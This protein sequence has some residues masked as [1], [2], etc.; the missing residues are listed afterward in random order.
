[1]KFALLPV[2]LF[3]SSFALLAQ[4]ITL[5][6]NP[7][8]VVFCGQPGQVVSSIPVSVS[9][10]SGSV[11]Y[12]VAGI[13]SDGNWLT[14]N[15]S[16]ATATT[17][18]YPELLVGIQGSV[19]PFPAGTYTGQITLTDVNGA[20]LGVIPVSLQVSVDGC[21]A[22]QTGLLFPN[23]GPLTFALPQ[24]VKSGTLLN[25]FNTF[26]T[27]VTVVPETST[28]NGQNWL[29]TIG[30]NLTVVT[31]LPY[32]TPLGVGVDTTSLTA[33]QSYAG[34]VVVN[35]SVS[36]SLDIPVTVLV[37][38]ADS[39]GIVA[40]PSPLSLTI[41]AGTGASAI[42][43]QLTNAGTSAISATLSASAGWLTVDQ[44]TVEIAPGDTVPFTATITESGLTA[45]PNAASISVGSLLT[46]P[47]TA[48]YA[49]AS[50]LAATPNPINLSTST[51]TAQ[52]SV[53]AAAGSVPFSATASSGY[54]SGWLTVSPTS[55]I[56]S[57]SNPAS[58]T[59]SLQPGM[60]PSG[61]AIGFITL[62][63][64]DGSSSLTIPVNVNAGIDGSLS[65][66]AAQLSF[67]YQQNGPTPASQTL[68]VSSTAAASYT[69]QFVGGTWLTVTP[70]NLTTSAGGTLTLTANV[71]PA[72]LAANTYPGQIVL[73]NA[74][75]GAQGMVPVTLTV[76]APVVLN[77]APQSLSFNTA[78]GGSGSGPA[79]TVQLTS[80]GAPASFTVS[81]TNF[82]AVSASANTTPATLTVG[83]N[84]SVAGTLA[85]GTYNGT[86]TIASTATAGSQTIAVTLVVSATIPQISTIVNS[87][88]LQPG[89]VAPG[90]IVTIFGTGLAAPAGVS[91][92]LTGGMLPT[93]L[94]N[95]V[96][97]FDDHDAPL[98]YVSPG[99]INAIVPFEIAGQAVT[100]LIV[101]QQGTASTALA[102]R[103]ADTVPAIFSSGQTGSGPGAIL[104]DDNTANG[105][106]N[107]AAAGSVVQ[108]FATGEGLSQ[109]AVTGSLTPAQPPFRTPLAAVSVTIGGLP[110]QIA[111]AGEAPGLVAGILQVNAIVSPGLSSGAQPVVLKVGAA[112]NNTQSITVAVQ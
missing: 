105:P 63:P 37:G 8:P 46:I 57:P 36:A 56:A 108:I 110:A 6:A 9:S 68:T 104:N 12:L 21:A 26:P 20:R 47:V 22:G 86:V 50:K 88:S 85:A 64:G 35:S 13:A 4:S 27:D 67:A 77:A 102:L 66:A 70:A 53:A 11:T 106:A 25:I 107:P 10:S 83:L 112:V 44:S 15:P 78:V 98:I 74:S 109:D 82:L 96:V 48:N 29:T 90:E 59:V 41:P 7:S 30:L 81:A 51:P 100:N 39:S 71:S 42:P 92:T 61:P 65:F 111:F 40:T 62:K 73:T 54:N 55:G 23:S 49:M 32:P 72:G 24:G 52:I 76:G 80:T 43:M 99:Q 84:S 89:P 103:V 101:S 69:V 97:S 60:L 79:Q 19:I 87:A 58:L 14:V 18:A 1:M 45:G 34:D 28:A 31:G 38:S 94:E 33:G 5:T 16:F 93:T 91:A 2:F 17:T 3:L 75:S 95:V